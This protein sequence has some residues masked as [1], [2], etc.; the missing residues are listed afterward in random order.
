MGVYINP[1]NG[2]TKEQFLEVYGTRIT[3]HDA[4]NFDF[5]RDDA[6]PVCL[7][8]NGDFSAAGVGYNSE[9]IA[10]FC[11]KADPRPRTYFEVP[12]DRL[13][14]HAG[15]D[16]GA[17]KSLANKQNVSDENKEQIFKL[18]RPLN[19]EEGEPD[20]LLVYNEDGSVISFIPVEDDD[21]I[22]ALFGEEY[23]IY[24]RGRVDPKDGMN[25]LHIY[26]VVDN[27]DW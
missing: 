1:T 10:V 4:E 22:M 24:V 26:E 20:Q 25:M 18:Q 27:Q 21:E 3:P 2:M 23:K 14:M 19:T 17:L 13:D 15:I 9:E 8:D 16:S 11:D 12:F 7:I 6:L 5:T